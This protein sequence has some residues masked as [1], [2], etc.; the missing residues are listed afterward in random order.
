MEELMGTVGSRLY[1]A[2]LDKVDLQKQ[3]DEW[4]VAVELKQVVQQQQA[5]IESG[6][7]GARAQ[8]KGTPPLSA[9]SHERAARP[10][11]ARSSPL[12]SWNSPRRNRADTAASSP[13]SAPRSARSRRS[14]EG[15]DAASSG[16][17]NALAT[18][19]ARFEKSADARAEEVR[20]L[21]LELAS[22]R[23]AQEADRD[24]ATDLRRALADAEADTAR[25]EARERAVEGKLAEA[26]ARVLGEQAQ[27]EE[28]EAR[29][30]EE[31]AL[32]SALRGDLASRSARIV[33]LETDAAALRERRDELERLA[34]DLEARAEANA[35]ATRDAEAA[36]TR[37]GAELAAAVQATA[38]E[39]RRA[40]ELQAALE[41]ERQ[42]LEQARREAAAAHELRHERE[43]AAAL[44]ERQRA[45]EAAEEAAARRQALLEAPL[46]ADTEVAAL[47][48]VLD[49]VS[50]AAQETAL[51][52]QRVRG[53]RDELAARLQRGAEEGEG[54]SD[55]PQRD[56]TQGGATTTK[57]LHALF[58]D[59][60][61]VDGGPRTDAPTTATQTPPAGP[62]QQ[63]FDRLQSLQAAELDRQTDLV[64]TL[65]AEL[66]AAN[67]RG[68]D[69]ER[70]LLESQRQ[71]S[72]RAQALRAREQE[73]SRLQGLLE[74]QRARSAVE[75]ERLRDELEASRREAQALTAQLATARAPLAIPASCGALVDP[76]HS[77]ALA[78]LSSPAGQSSESSGAGSPPVKRSRL[79]GSA[80]EDE[81]ELARAPPRAP[82]PATLAEATER[83]ALAF[84]AL[85]AERRRR[86]RRLDR[87][88][89]QHEEETAAL[90]LEHEQQL[91]AVELAYLEELEEAR[92]GKVGTPVLQSLRASSGLTLGQLG[93]APDA[94]A[95]RDGQREAELEALRREHALELEKLRREHALEPE[96]HRREHARELRR[97]EARHEEELAGLRARSGAGSPARCRIT[98]GSQAKQPTG[99]T[100]RS[101]G[102]ELA[103][104]GAEPDAGGAGSSL[105]PV[106]R[107]L[108]RLHAEMETCAEE[109]ERRG[110]ALA[111]CQDMVDELQAFAEQKKHEAEG[112]R[113]Q[114]AAAHREQRDLAARLHAGEGLLAEA[115]AARRGG[116]EQ[117]RPQRTQDAR[118]DRGAGLAPADARRAPV[119][120]HERLRT[121]GG[122]AAP[123]RRARER[124]DAGD[125]QTPRAQAL[126]ADQAAAGRQGPPLFIPAHM[127]TPEIVPFADDAGTPHSA[128]SQETSWSDTAAELAP[129]RLQSKKKSKGALHKLAKM[130]RGGRS[131]GS[132]AKETAQDRSWTAQGGERPQLDAA[133]A[134]L[135]APSAPTLSA[136]GAHRLAQARPSGFLGP[137]VVKWEQDAL[138][139]SQELARADPEEA[140]L[141][142]AFTTQGGDAPAAQAA[143]GR[144]PLSQTWSDATSEEEASRARLSTLHEAED[145]GEETGDGEAAHAWGAVDAEVSW[146][147]NAAVTGDG[148]ASPDISP[149]ERDPGV[150]R[151][152]PLRSL[153]SALERDGPAARQL[154]AAAAYY[155]DEVSTSVLQ[156]SPP[157]PRSVSRPAARPPAPVRPPPE[158]AFDDEAELSARVRAWQLR[159]SA[160]WNDDEEAVD[161]ASEAGWRLATAGAPDEPATP[162]HQMQLN[163][164]HGNA[165]FQD[166]GR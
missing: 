21:E 164:L 43:R 72:E 132:A 83:L 1:R 94:A 110:V 160:V 84:A 155:E 146:R 103:G 32:S 20:A 126:D 162:R 131:K 58:G 92:G 165:L 77:A 47:Q 35:A 37:L 116:A 50:A 95:P 19:T 151:R 38:A 34:R 104:L 120:A 137:Q 7:N 108:A 152:T 33:R 22:A 51:E 101:L 88:S 107:E 147:R 54:A 96:A 64:E 18:V 150:E 60:D 27:R 87:L 105:A 71:A 119:G 159:K 86:Q 142:A 80:S 8:E 121:A 97:V 16:L 139:Q 112:V 122:R 99:A 49:S 156:G 70:A 149:G 118:A 114:L 13:A 135:R 125:A 6:A 127:G 138:R 65:Q 153:G 23:A 129:H 41:L 157:V 115:Q 78:P 45:V 17:E 133:D 79:R 5:A 53:E 29:L 82:P 81:D 75:L 31:A 68:E 143:S 91:Q 161:R 145:E 25:A 76:D 59:G 130:L 52:L 85:D 89:A 113:E 28:L 3:L 12:K 73:S 40:S 111:E 140:A 134:P 62:T 39:R 154:G 66:D 56:A 100:R 67:R 14:V 15:G 163:S 55:R 36:R 141:L 26:E 148:P 10:A 30:G 98:A 109:C 46:D 144:Q 106:E 90:R 166:A 158:A 102:G 136:Q 4:C 63:D 124:A 2:E 42:R 57:E 11:E 117:R 93:R 48:V 9:R 24:E 123:P 61:A 44:D 74:E 69:L 128:I